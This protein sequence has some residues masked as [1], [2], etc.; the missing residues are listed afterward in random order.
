M[1][2]LAVFLAITLAPLALAETRRD[3]SAVIEDISEKLMENYRTRVTG[4][5]IAV[6]PIKGDTKNFSESDKAQVRQ[7][8]ISMLQSSGYS[9]VDDEH[10][11]ELK[12]I[13]A[14]QAS[15]AV[16]DKQV[17][18]MGNKAG[19]QQIIA[20]SFSEI[21]GKYDATESDVSLTVLLR[22]SDVKS[23]K[24]VV[25]KT[26]ESKYSDNIYHES[27]FVRDTASLA[28]AT[29]KWATLV[30]S[31]YYGVTGASEASKAREADTK[32]KDTK[33]TAAD[34][35]KYTADSDKYNKNAQTD[36]LWAGGMFGACILSWVFQHHLDT[37]PRD[38]ADY[39]KYSV[40][41][42]P[43]RNQAGTSLALNFHLNI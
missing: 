20:I 37:L 36:Y 2:A 40:G 13:E 15:G 7:R 39:H 26:I 43:W 25:A 11:Q 17:Q 6:L 27:Y 23:G 21:I 3:K 12:S 31:A 33:V 19:V 41:I 18:A 38:H 8:F 24:I 9:V 34:K 28:L 1:K 30:G 22:A 29:T 5:T 4:K 10:T 35:A 32:A 42:E 14:Y 16:M